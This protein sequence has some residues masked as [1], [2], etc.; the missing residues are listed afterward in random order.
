[1][2]SGYIH[3]FYPP[4]LLF[5]QPLASLRLPPLIH[6][7]SDVSDDPLMGVVRVSSKVFSS[8]QTH[9]T[10]LTVQPVLLVGGSAGLDGIV[11]REGRNKVVEVGGEE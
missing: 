1:M 4:G 2:K 3:L 9:S 6:T 11:R 7:D 8:Q 10:H 5:L